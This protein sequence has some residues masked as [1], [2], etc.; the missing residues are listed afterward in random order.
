MR[1]HSFLEASDDVILPA[2]LIGPG[3]EFRPQALKPSWSAATSSGALAGTVADGVL[4][5]CEAIVIIT[6][7]RGRES[8][9]RHASHLCTVAKLVAA[10]DVRRINMRRL[11]VLL[12]LLGV[13][14]LGVLALHVQPVAVAQEATPAMEEMMP[15]GVIFELVSLTTGVDLASPADLLVF[16]VGLEP[17]TVLPVDPTPG[18]GVFLVGSGSLTV[19]VDGEVRVTRGGAVD[20]M[21]A[22][23]AGEAVT[24]EAGD[25]AYIPANVPG[26]IR[27]QGQ[28]AAT[29]V[30]FIVYPSEGMTGEATPVP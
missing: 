20:A 29:A 5:A 13:V 16:Q 10:Q 11:S 7:R 2:N 17:G 14:L 4:I 23:S 18:Q 8:G 24:L 25:I 12:S 21:E 30:A 3:G 1:S 15:E 6:A 26:E 22:V 27:N 28:E 19:Q 9:P